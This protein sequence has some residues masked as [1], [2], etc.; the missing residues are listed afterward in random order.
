MEAVIKDRNSIEWIRIKEYCTRRLE[1]LRADNEGDL[2]PV[3]TAKVR[4]MIAYCNEI[5][6]LD[7]VGPALKKV[8]NTRYY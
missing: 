2:D 7:Q 8:P 3:E 5:L 6:S 1:E 4:G